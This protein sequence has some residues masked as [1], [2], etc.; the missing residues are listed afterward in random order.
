MKLLFLKSV[1]GGRTKTD[2]TVASFSAVIARGRRSGGNCVPVLPVRR[3]S[4]LSL[5]NVGK[6]LKQ[7]VPSFLSAVA[8]GQ[9][10]DRDF[11]IYLFILGMLLFQPPPP[12]PPTSQ[13]QSATLLHHHHPPSCWLCPLESSRLCLVL[14]EPRLHFT[15]TQAGAFKPRRIKKQPWQAGRQA[16]KGL[17]GLAAAAIQKDFSF[18]Q[19]A[20]KAKGV[21]AVSRPRDTSSSN[22][23][24]SHL[25]VHC[26]FFEQLIR[27]QVGS[28]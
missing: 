7:I 20:F 3:S 13:L 17:L 1:F 6:R 2:K 25:A 24:G 4:V 14:R 28:R 10:W 23:G 19:S 15:D 16:G 21:R 5:W 12:I 8:Q 27:Q 9:P 11:F 22:K 26:I 18:L